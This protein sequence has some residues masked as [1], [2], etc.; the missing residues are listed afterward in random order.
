M[1]VGPSSNSPARPGVA[2]PA[3]QGNEPPPPAS[4]PTGASGS[5][6]YNGAP[7][8]FPAPPQ[9][10]FVMQSQPGYGQIGPAYGMQPQGQMMYQPSPGY[11]AQNGVV[12]SQPGEPIIVLPHTPGSILHNGR[13]IMK[14]QGMPPAD[15]TPAPICV[16]GI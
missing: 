16:I 12:A 4:Y 3:S 14:G 1:Q 13:W 8:Q 11:Y 2:Q 9:P 7:A 10:G 5:A 15:V 6:N